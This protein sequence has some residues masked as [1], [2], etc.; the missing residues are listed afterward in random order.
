MN[1]W[2]GSLCPV[3]VKEQCYKT[4]RGKGERGGQEQKQSRADVHPYCW[5]I[6]DLQPPFRGDVSC[7]VCTV[8]AAAC[9]GDLQESPEPHCAGQTLIPLAVQGPLQ[10]M[11]ETA[12]SRVL[13]SAFLAPCRHHAKKTHEISSAGQETSHLPACCGCSARAGQRRNGKGQAAHRTLGESTTESQESTKLPQQSPRRTHLH[14]GV[15]GPVFL[16]HQTFCFH[17]WKE[18]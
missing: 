18:K 5:P 10:G 14:V 3:Q 8:M 16:P 7:P 17:D 11:A 15:T 12:P 13:S 1:G 4:P 9:Q 6:S 2:F